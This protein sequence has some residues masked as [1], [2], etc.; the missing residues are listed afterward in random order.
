MLNRRVLL[1][2]PLA[3]FA[4]AGC[5]PG[6]Y[7]VALRE[8]DIALPPE[9]TADLLRALRAF[10][11]ANGFRFAVREFR[12]RIG[13][14]HVFEMRRRDLWIA[15]VNPL[16]D[17]PHYNPPLDPDGNLIMEVDQGTFAVTFVRGDR[18]PEPATLDAMVQAF[19][20]AMEQVPGVTATIT[21]AHSPY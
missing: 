1:V 11:R 13:T 16:K 21:R 10:A 9:R 4:L 17:T 6:L 14:S 18:D 15:G 20:G 2:S 5:G 12:S 19:I 8:A 3:A 7:K